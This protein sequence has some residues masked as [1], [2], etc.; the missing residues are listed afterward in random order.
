MIAIQ[1]QAAL[2]VKIYSDATAAGRVSTGLVKRAIGGTMKRDDFIIFR[3]ICHRKHCAS[4][5]S[6][7]GS[8]AVA[9]LCYAC[10]GNTQ[11]RF[12]A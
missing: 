2:G 11:E 10:N 4:S 5:V 3:S 1:S 7:I 9:G 8:L 12:T 6:G